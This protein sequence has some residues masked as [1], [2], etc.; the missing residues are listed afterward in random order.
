MLAAIEEE[1]AR[2][3]VSIRIEVYPGT[4]HGFAVP[5]APIYDP[6]ASERHFERTL[7]LWDR[8]TAAEPAG[9]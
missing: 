5:G 9:V 1:A 4:N 2:H 8:N 7:E 6:E 3:G